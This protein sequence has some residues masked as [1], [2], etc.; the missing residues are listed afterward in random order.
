MSNRR[1]K[2]RGIV[3]LLVGVMA[4]ISGIIIKNSMVWSGLCLCVIGCFNVFEKE[5]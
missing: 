5:T 4:F 1:K 2:I 3:E